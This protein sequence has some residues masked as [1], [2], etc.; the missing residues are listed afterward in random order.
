V[1]LVIAVVSALPAGAVAG[2]PGAVAVF[3]TV[4]GVLHV[5]IA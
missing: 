2:L 5:M 3:F 4:A 1:I